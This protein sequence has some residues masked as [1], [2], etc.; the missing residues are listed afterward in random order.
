MEERYGRCG[1]MS[2]MFAFI[3]GLMGLKSSDIS[4]RKGKWP[5]GKA[6]AKIGKYD[7]VLAFDNGKVID[8]TDTYYVGSEPGEREIRRAKLPGKAAHV[9]KSNEK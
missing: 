4:V 7:W 2:L 6:K 9:M 1:E 3:A 5:K 8:V